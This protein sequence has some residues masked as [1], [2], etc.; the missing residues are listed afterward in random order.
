MFDEQGLD[1]SM[2]WYSSELLPLGLYAPVSLLGMLVRCSSFSLSSTRFTDNPFCD[3]LGRLL[4]LP[5]LALSH[6]ISPLDRPTMEHA[7]FTAWT[8]I[9]SGLMTLA[10]QYEIK[11]GF[12]LAILT[13]SQVVGMSC[14]EGLGMLTKRARGEVHLVSCP[15]SSQT[16][17]AL[18]AVAQNMCFRPFSSGWVCRCATC[19]SGDRHHHLP[20]RIVDLRPPDRSDGSRRPGR[21]HHRQPLRPPRRPLYTCCSAALPPVRSRPAGGLH[22]GSGG[23]DGRFGWSVREVRRLLERGAETDLLES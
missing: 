5:Q 1:R 4:Q 7:T 20:H 11:S 22:L 23:D 15:H 9:L 10:T 16:N 18:Q 21:T 8:T 17:A 3:D 6:W 19:S 14:S 2:S 12:L 13:G